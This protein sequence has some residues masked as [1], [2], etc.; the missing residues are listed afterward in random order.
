LHAAAKQIVAAHGGRFPSDVPTLMTLPGVGRYTAGAIA[1]IAFDAPAPILE[2]NTVRLLSR[3]IGYRGDPAKSAGQRLLWQTAEA[4]VP[5]R[6]A[7][8]FN[9]ALMELGSL[10]CTPA[11]PRCSACPVAAH[12]AALAA[13]LQDSIPAA[14]PKAPTI[15]VRE[16]AVIVRKNG[17]VLLRKCAPGERWAGLWDFP[18]FPL[19]AARPRAA[20]DELA[21]KV[22]AQ[23]GITIKSGQLLVILRHGVTRYRITLECYQS[24][25]AAG[26]LRTS[27]RQPARWAPLGALDEYP[28]SAT[29]RR[30]ARLLNES[31]DAR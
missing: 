28:L 3:L 26:R 10:V 15:A 25:H 18:R 2:A 27:A 6:N 13:G 17:A 20:S 24:R 21:E 23:T 14:A 5:P 16:A 9:Q 8:R 12:C 19:E 30:L 11:A 22:R 31:P 4:L 1:S 7:S 29:A